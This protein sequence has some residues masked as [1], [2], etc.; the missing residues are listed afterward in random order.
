MRI[1][2]VFPI[3]VTVRRETY[4]SWNVDVLEDAVD[5]NTDLPQ[6]N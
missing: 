2:E 4:K 6:E 3:T 1:S 5:C